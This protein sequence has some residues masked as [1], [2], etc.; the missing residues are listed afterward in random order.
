[1]GI[2]CGWKLFAHA[3][4][5]SEDFELNERNKDNVTNEKENN[6]SNLLNK[7]SSQVSN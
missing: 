3:D 7:D 1:M 4:H 2:L 5:Y 6:S